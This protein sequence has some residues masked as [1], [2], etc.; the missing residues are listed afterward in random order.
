VLIA[1]AD[2][3]LVLQDA[4][5]WSDVAGNRTCA[6]TREMR[7]RRIIDRNF[8]EQGVHIEPVVEADTVGALFAHISTLGL[9]AVACTTWLQTYGLPAGMSARPMAEIG[10]RP[11]VGLI[12]LNRRPASIVAQALE[13]A[14]GRA[15]FG[16][17]FAN[18]SQH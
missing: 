15:D 8:A 6:L 1:P 2:D 16:S 5:A 3:P 17:M 10:P 12:T 13:A 18:R 7:N 11:A 14:A 9:A 4:V